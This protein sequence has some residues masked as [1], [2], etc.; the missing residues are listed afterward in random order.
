MNYDDFLELVKNR[1]SI[2]RF[3]P[4]PVPDELIDKI[5]EAARWAPSGANS[6]P[7]EFIVVKK[8]ELRDKIVEL[9]VENQARAVKMEL[10]REPRLRHPYHENPL[11]HTPG[12]AKAPVYILLC[13]DTRTKEA[14]PV[15]NTLEIGDADFISSMANC[16]L[17]ISM[18]AYVLGLGGQWITT[19]ALP[20]VKCQ[21]KALLGIPEEIDVYDMMAIGYP[22]MEP[23]SRLVRDR[24]EM[25]HYD[26]YD[27]AK[28]KTDEKVNDFIF[29]IYQERKH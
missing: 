6:Q 25:I 11:T 4:N 1:R 23:P 28:Y 29:S 3:K 18:A 17:Y 26:Y 16:F 19:V 7:W 27:K 2:R 9:F 5:V 14:Y 20:F 15:S 13:G 22:N 12:F 10:T 8:N 24:E 21:I